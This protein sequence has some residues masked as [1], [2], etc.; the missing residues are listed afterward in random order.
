[1]ETSCSVDPAAIVL[2]AA[3]RAASLVM[4]GQIATPGTALTFLVRAYVGVAPVVPG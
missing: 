3:S 1:M 2:V 4:A